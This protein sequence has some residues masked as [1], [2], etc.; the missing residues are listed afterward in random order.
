[1]ALVP[2]VP[3]ILLFL[4]SPAFPVLHVPETWLVDKA[5]NPAFES[6]LIGVAMMV[7]VAVAALAV[8][9]T[10][11]AVAV[12]FFEGAGY[13]YTH[14]ISLIVVASAFGEGVKMIGV[15]QVVSGLVQA[16]PGL[17]LP[18]AGLVACA[19]AWLSGSGM[20]STQSLFSLFAR[21]ALLLEIDPG[22]VGAVVSL[23][24]A[25]GRTMSPVA[26]VALMSPA[27]PRRTPWTW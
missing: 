2:L 3:L 13:A 4:T 27:S 11:S 14:I 8:W 21:P 23:A 10:P 18:L 1:M 6:R 20:A 15:D 5:G 12:S 9:R 16:M 17:L 25:A 24:A 22:R 19:F 7:G 26:A